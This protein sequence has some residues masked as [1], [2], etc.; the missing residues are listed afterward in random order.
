MDKYTNYAGTY[1]VKYITTEKEYKENHV[2]ETLAA[3]E[4]LFVDTETT[5]INPRRDKLCLL[6]LK[7]TDTVFVI[8]V[9]TLPESVFTEIMGIIN[10]EN[11]TWVLHNA[12]FDLKFLYASGV[13]V[14]ANIKD[15]MLMETAL[16]QGDTKD[17]VSLRN[18]AMNY[19]SIELD[20]TEQT[21]DWSGYLTSEQ[22]TYAAND[23]IVLEQVYN[24]VHD[25]VTARGLEE[26][27]TIENNAVKA[28]ARLEFTG[29]HIDTKAL[30]EEK[31]RIQKQIQELT[32][33]F[34]SER[35]NVNSPMQLKRYLHGKGIQVKKTDKEEL[36]KFVEYDIVHQ[37]LMIKQLESQ[38]RGFDTL[39]ASRDRHTDRAYCTYNQNHTSTGRYSTVKPNIQG[40]P[41][42]DSVRRMI[43]APPDK[44]L[45][46]CDYSQIE[47]RIMAEVA[48]DPAMMQAYIDGKD[49]HRTTAAT[50]NHI[51]YDEVTS[52]QR[53]AAKAMNF[54]L[55]YGMSGKTFIRY[56]KT[57][58]G[59]DIDPDEAAEIT[60]SFFGLYKEVCNRIYVMEDK[61]TNFEST[62]SGRI[63]IWKDKFPSMNVRCNYEIQGLGADII[64]IALA[65][66][67]KEMVCTGEAELMI[68]VHD[69][70]VI[71]VDK[72]RAEELAVKLKTIMEES[73]AVYLK[74]VPVIAEVS[75]GDN[76]AAK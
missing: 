56:A 12:K 74:K 76:W 38:V 3:T 2:A 70:I 31:R 14:V 1:T 71:A 8:K 46:I 49:L 34:D 39:L 44:Q 73:A 58:Y 54:G 10:K 25:E 64:K 57:N 75:I 33:P 55:I 69:E 28:T 23:V 35:V 18:M 19:C 51:P 67:E 42:A 6:Q 7:A 21:S 16:Y 61:E 24:A 29:V 53:K 20:K 66:V 52:E 4:L 36:S 72:D 9:N 48:E 43:I 41:H 59:V 68:T 47:L 32:K 63:R 22:L 17:R 40:L 50:V 15:T 30:R 60:D 45:V 27:A 26:V 37:I 11:K 62:K 65:R 5:G 13:N